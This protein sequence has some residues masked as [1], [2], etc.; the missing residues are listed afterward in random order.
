M[1][2]R[3]PMRTGWNTPGTAQLADSALET[4]PEHSVSSVPCSKS[5][6]TAQ[7]GRRRSSNRMSFKKQSASR[8]MIS[9]LIYD[10]SGSL[11]GS[12]FLSLKFNTKSYSSSQ[13]MSAAYS[14]P[15][16]APAELPAT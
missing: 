1:Y 10:S 12:T 2:V 11:L 15:A 16:I 4:L 14:A 9:G 8:S 3:P 13:D 6:A 7:N 5:T